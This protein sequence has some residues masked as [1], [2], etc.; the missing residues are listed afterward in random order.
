MERE[1]YSKLKSRLLDGTI[2]IDAKN[3]SINFSNNNAIIA[4][5]PFRENIPQDVNILTQLTKFI[6]SDGKKGIDFY[7]KYINK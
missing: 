1:I 7:E 6:L 4:L 3:N 2:Y 5:L